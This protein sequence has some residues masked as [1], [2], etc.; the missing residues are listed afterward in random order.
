[1]L[2]PS[3]DHVFAWPVGPQRRRSLSFCLLSSLHRPKKR[4]SSNRTCACF[5][6]N[7]IRSPWRPLRLA[8]SPAVA[9]PGP[10][11]TPAE[12]PDSFAQL[13]TKQVGALILITEKPLTLSNLKPRGSRLLAE[14]P[15]F[16]LARNQFASESF[17][18]YVDFK[19]LEKEARE[20]RQRWE[21]EEKRLQEHAAANPTPEPTPDTEEELT[22]SPQ[23]DFQISS[24]P[25]SPELIP[26]T[27]TADSAKQSTTQRELSESIN[28]F[29][30]PLSMA[31]FGGRAKWPEAVGAALAFEGD[32]YVLRALVLNT[33]DNRPLPLPFV[34]QIASGPALTPNSPNIMPGDV[35]L[36]V[37]LS[38]DHA[39]IYDGMI[40]AFREQTAFYQTAGASIKMPSSPFLA[41]EGKTGINVK[42][43]LLP[44]L[45]NEMALA[46]PKPASSSKSPASEAVTGDTEAN[47]DRRSVRSPELMPIIAISIKDKDAVKQLI[48]RIFES[49]GLKGANMLA[50]TEKREDTEIVS[51]AN[52]F[53]YAFIGNFLL[54]TPDAALTRR[55]VDSYLSGETLSANGRFKNATRWQS[56]QVQG[57]VYVGSDFVD[58][59]VFAGKQKPQNVS[60]QSN[61][62]IEP[63]TYSLANEGLGPLHE[64]RIPRS[65][66]TMVVAGISSQADESPIFTNESVAKNVLRTLVSAQ[67]TFKETKGNGHYGSMDELVAAGLITKDLFERYGYKIE[68][69]VLS[70]KF[71]A[72]A[73]P[74]EYGK[75]GR[76]SFYV[77]ESGVL[78]GGDHA[79]GPATLSDSPINE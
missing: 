74:L 33:A 78:R 28:S 59:Y 14:D 20:Q 55:A 61:Q 34:P 22:V 70:N 42:D 63:L 58:N 62:P 16:S 31:L 53:S 36:F 50:H 48:P 68:V 9:T 66:L 39:Q 54:V 21:E 67:A 13:Q 69:S 27:A 60:L 26:Q 52:L 19:A 15:N 23:D 17:F 75:T 45:G 79:G 35:D 71:E 32:S 56:S 41:F 29:M 7:W 46:I 6:P 4:K 72:T 77:D 11:P 64:A 44:L 47:E 18:L 12:N 40:K 2:I 49:L 51:Y 10:G 43:E 37:A 24:A 8:R 76:R 3:P 5:Y 30:V 65:L 38:L 1:M 73:S 25:R 57:Q